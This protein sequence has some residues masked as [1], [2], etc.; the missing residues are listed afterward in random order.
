MPFN[1]LGMQLIIDGLAIRGLSKLVDR[2]YN[3]QEALI[4]AKES[5]NKRTHIYGLVIT[6]ISMPLLDGY[7]FSE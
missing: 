2:A 3:G 1:V 7:E 5:F 4:K 6:D